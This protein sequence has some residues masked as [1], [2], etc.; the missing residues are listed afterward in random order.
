MRYGQ[1]RGLQFKASER[2]GRAQD[3]TKAPI[4]GHFCCAA[5]LCLPSPAFCPSFSSQ[6]G[7]LPALDGAG[8]L[9]RD[10]G[11]GSPLIQAARPRGPTGPGGRGG[12]PTDSHLFAQA[13]CWFNSQ[14]VCWLAEKKFRVAAILLHG[15]PVGLH[16]R[17]LAPSLHIERACWCAPPARRV[18]RANRH[19]NEGQ[20]ESVRQSKSQCVACS[21]FGVVDSFPLSWQ[22]R[23]A[24][25]ED[26]NSTSST[27]RLA[28]SE[29][30]EPASV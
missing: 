23:M 2:T 12:G 21:T 5:D 22:N 29:N 18:S 8:L 10:A 3:D 26:K 30:K 4:W 28:C 19:P 17:P 6:P 14:L 16:V 15:S 25:D 9:I 7:R 13:R 11:Q 1:W 24:R 20:L 27:L